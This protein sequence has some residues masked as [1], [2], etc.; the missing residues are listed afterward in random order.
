[1]NSILYLIYGN[2]RLHEWKN[3]AVDL[4]RVYL[5]VPRFHPVSIIPKLVNMYLQLNITLIMRTRGRKV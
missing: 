2:F 4:V 1:M 3:V 5:Q